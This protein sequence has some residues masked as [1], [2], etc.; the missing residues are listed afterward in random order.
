MTE[1]Q[2]QNALELADFIETSPYRFQMS[3]SIANP[4]CGTAGCIGGHAACLWPEI[5]DTK[6]CEGPAFSWLEKLFAKKLGLTQEQHDDLCY[7]PTCTFASID[8]HAAAETLRR[9]ARTGEI[10]WSHVGATK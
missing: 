9:Y 1:Q 5:Q 8:R 2:R 6:A 3:S 10:D 4:Q 7:Y